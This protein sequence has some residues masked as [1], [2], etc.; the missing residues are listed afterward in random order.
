MEGSISA[1]M[2]L[3]HQ[4][5]MT[6]SLDFYV[7]ECLTNLAFWPLFFPHIQESRG[8]KARLCI[9]GVSNTPFLMTTSVLATQPFSMWLLKHSYILPDAVIWVSWETVQWKQFFFPME[10][11]RH[12]QHQTESPVLQVLLILCRASLHEASTRH[13]ALSQASRVTTLWP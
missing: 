3:S 6:Q 10:K 8:D 1:G 7:P 9:E 11:L 5:T 13:T 2:S 12:E 4:E